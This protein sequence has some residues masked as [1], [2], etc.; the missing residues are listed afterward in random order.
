MTSTQ[1]GYSDNRLNEEIDSTSIR[2]LA[3]YNYDNFKVNFSTILRGNSSLGS[4]LNRTGYPIVIPSETVPT[5]DG[6]SITQGGE[7]TKIHGSQYGG[8]IDAIYVAV[9]Y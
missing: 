3:E 7:A 8:V 4:Y 2:S 5:A 6:F 1:L 9:P